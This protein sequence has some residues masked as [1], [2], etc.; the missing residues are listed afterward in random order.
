MNNKGFTV[1]ELAIAIVVLVAIP[2]CIYG[3]VHNIY[4]LWHSSFTPLTGQVV[5]RAVGVFLAPLGIV[6]GYL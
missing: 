6:M 1:I 2:A 4:L 5:I 3:W